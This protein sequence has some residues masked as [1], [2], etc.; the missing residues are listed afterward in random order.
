MDYT[1]TIDK[2]FKEDISNWSNPGTSLDKLEE[3]RIKVTIPV[4]WWNVVNNER[5]HHD[6]KHWQRNAIINCLNI[7]MFSSNRFI[8]I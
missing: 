6:L 5:F 1:V 7:A 4:K 2:R 8:K 3:K